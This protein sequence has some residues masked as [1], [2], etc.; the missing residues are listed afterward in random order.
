MGLPKTHKTDVTSLSAINKHSWKFYRTFHSMPPVS[1]CTS[2][3]L[4]AY[5][6][7]CLQSFYNFVSLNSCDMRTRSFILKGCN[8]ILLNRDSENI[9]YNTLAIVYSLGIEEVFC[10]LALNSHVDIGSNLH[11]MSEWLTNCP[12]TEN[13]VF[14]QFVEK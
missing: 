9:H 12:Q 10:L 6:E 14:N 13:W 1:T 4:S 11:R 8:L 2:R 5:N 3:A 7:F